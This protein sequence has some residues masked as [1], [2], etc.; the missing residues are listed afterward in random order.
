M[1]VAA[2]QVL[3]L[4][5]LQ[6]GDFRPPA[7]PL[8]TVDPYTSCWSMS[9][10][11]HDDWPRHWTGAVHA[12]CGFIRVD[13]QPMRFMGGWQALAKTADQ[14]SVEVRPTQTIYVFACGGVELT[15]TFTSPL[16]MD[17]LD[18][19]SRPASYI[20]FDVRSNDGKK[21]DVRIYFDATGEWAVNRPDQLVEW[22][23][24]TA[25]GLDVLRIGT[26]EQKVLAKK[27][28]DLR[29]DWGYL[30]VAV[31]KGQSSTALAPAD[32]V[33][34]SFMEKGEL[35]TPDDTQ[36]PRAAND[37]WPTLAA[38]LN[39]GEVGAE[40]VRR[41]LT[42]AYDD[43]YSI[44]YFQKRLRAWWRR[45]ENATPEDMLQAA[46][47]DYP[48]VMKRCADFDARLLADAKRCG[49]EEYATLCALVYRQA[50]A[51]HKLVAG[52]DGTPLFFSK[53]CFSNGSIGTVDVTYPSSPLFLV[54]NPVLLKS[55]MEPIF[56]FRESGQWT[57]PFA[58]HDVGTYPIAN[59]QTYGGDM[60]VEE[61]GNMIVLAAAIAQVEGNADYA[62]KHWKTL[63]EWAGYLKEKGF[64]PENQLCTDD[65]AG[66]LARNANL[67][68]KAI[69][70]LGGYGKLAGMLGDQ[71]AS[72]EYTSLAKDLAAKWQAA[73]ADG[74]HYSLTFDKKGTWSQ[75][76]NL[77]W[78]AALGLN[79]FPPDV[80][81]KEI[82]YY[83]TKQNRYGL[84]LDVRAGY[85]KSD[86]IMWTATM[87]DSQQTFQKLVH[88][89][90]LYLNDSPDRVP[91]SDWH[92]TE[93]GKVQGFRARS[94]VGGYFMK[95]LAEKLRSP[96]GALG[97]EG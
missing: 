39:V 53:E 82:A 64:D 18:L 75:K 73:A 6:A 31:P 81:R 59:G 14:K 47:K 48:A 63:T 60:P 38:M 44:E 80:A 5:M 70:A 66:H 46:E 11:L 13:G 52:P 30:L 65:F 41:H 89:I 69:V 96:K 45:N 78:D 24:L 90:Y 85:T 93:T 2:S 83:L 67:S 58:P 25:G 35:P 55:M 86:W 29:I 10:R 56:F 50:I 28:D 7:F 51:A 43:V 3:G 8:V 19:L 12:M 22:S 94:V 72:T 71:A 87:A 79:L 1:S 16:L 17:D 49:G 57:K 62:R 97:R 68:I 32:V 40:P 15:V 36:I 21:H 76:Y 37:R 95:M 91:V 33:R 88:P 54:Y 92:W 23:R 84:P 9:N 42:V 77:V 26:Q 27:G 61:S 20:T 34:A 4:G 74:D